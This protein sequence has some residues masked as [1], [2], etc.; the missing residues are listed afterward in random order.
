MYLSAST[1]VRTGCHFLVSLCAHVIETHVIIGDERI[2]LRNVVP[3]GPI[4]A[5]DDQPPAARRSR[6]GVQGPGHTCCIRTHLTFMLALCITHH[7]SQGG[8]LDRVVLDIG[9]KELNDGQTFTALSR[10]RER[11]GMLLEDF[12][13]ERFLTI[14]TSRSFLSRLAA[15]DRMRALEDRTRTRCNLPVLIRDARLV[16]P[17]DLPGMRGRPSGRDAGHRRGQRSG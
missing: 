16:R 6:G 4:K 7:K 15:L 5:S 13:L 10:C 8:T 2:N 3:V 9:S 1:G 11:D 14:G 17:A 12:T